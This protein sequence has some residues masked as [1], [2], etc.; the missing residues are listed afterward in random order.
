MTV[1]RQ[2]QPIRLNR[3]AYSG[4]ASIAVA[5]MLVIH[6][7]GMLA[8]RYFEFRLNF[9][10]VW[11]LDC[12]TCIAVDGRIPLGVPLFGGI[13]AWFLVG[14][15]AAG[16]LAVGKR[17]GINPR[18]YRAATL[19]GGISMAVFTL[20][21]LDVRYPGSLPSVFI[22][23]FPGV[24]ATLGFLVAAIPRPALME[25]HDPTPMSKIS[26]VAVILGPL[27]MALLSGVVAAVAVPLSA[28]AYIGGRD[29]RNR[30]AA[31]GGLITGILGF[32][33]RWNLSGRYDIF[34]LWY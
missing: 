14:L 1:L 23:V 12:T 11:F 30:R 26:L 32:L 17:I 15:A 27:S 10:P 22:T 18:L 4:L 9:H 20:L 6:L 13:T 31:I 21:A 34:G 24:V 25:V 3:A 2:I 8:G 5:W 7:V 19:V 33:L 29:A 28:A 16:V